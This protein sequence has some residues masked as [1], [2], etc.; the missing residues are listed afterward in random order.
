MVI[1]R[2]NNWFPWERIVDLTRKPVKTEWITGTVTPQGW[3][4]FFLKDFLEK[5]RNYHIPLYANQDYLVEVWVEHEGLRPLFEK[6]LEDKHVTLFFTRGRNSWSAFYEAY[7]RLKDV[8]RKIMILHFSDL[9]KYGLEMTEDIR[10]ALT[11]TFALEVEVKRVALTE[12]QVKEWNL[13]DTQMEAID[14]SRFIELIGQS[15]DPYINKEKLSETWQKIDEGR[16]EVED[17]IE[18]KDIEFLEE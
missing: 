8:D 6:A 9:D 7:N 16:A 14:P 11:E 17:W 3:I 5:L 13:V 10:R 2:K 1:H 15:V 4:N 12:T 18:E